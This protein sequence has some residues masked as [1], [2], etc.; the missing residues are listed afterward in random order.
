MYPIK[1][2]MVKPEHLSTGDEYVHRI[3]GATLRIVAIQD[4]YSRFGT[5]AARAVKA[6][7]VRTGETVDASF[8]AGSSLVEVRG[9]EKVAG[10]TEYGRAI[11]HKG[12]NRWH[13]T[14]AAG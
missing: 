14:L 5:L 10:W 13:Y 2:V 6:V 9:G 8:S 3:S 12:M 4:T 1:Y 7:N 11:W